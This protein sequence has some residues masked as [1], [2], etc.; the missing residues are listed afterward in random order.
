MYAIYV[1]ASQSSLTKL[2][3]I[4]MYLKYFT[5]PSHQLLHGTLFFKYL[6][7]ISLTTAQRGGPLWRLIS[8]VF[9]IRCKIE[10]GT[11]TSSHQYKKKKKRCHQSFIDLPYNNWGPL[12]FVMC[13]HVLPWKWMKRRIVEECKSRLQIEKFL[14]G[15]YDLQMAN[16]YHL[17]PY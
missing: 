11:L 3:I 12:K 4:Y 10:I 16:P 15:C 7:C 17:G 6:H 14:K 2:A 5:I 13:T 1:N 8:V 9:S